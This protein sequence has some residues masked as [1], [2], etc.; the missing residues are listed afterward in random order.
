MQKDV[1]GTRGGEEIDDGLKPKHHV[2]K[3]HLVERRRHGIDTDK[4]LYA[5]CRGEKI[6]EIKPETRH[7]ALRPY[8][9]RKEEQYD[10]EEDAD[11]DA[12]ITTADETANGHAEEDGR[13]EERNNE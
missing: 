4:S 2:F 8:R 13:Q 3:F 12:R 11:K 6:R 1:E 10:A 7:I 9:T 5:K